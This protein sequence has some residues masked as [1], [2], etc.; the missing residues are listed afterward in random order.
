MKAK[1]DVDGA[2]DALEK[3]ARNDPKNADHSYWLARFLDERKRYREAIAAYQECIR[4][5]PDFT[6]ARHR[7]GV[8]LYLN[9]QLDQG[10]QTTRETV[11]LFPGDADSHYGLGTLLMVASRTDESIKWFRE[12]IRID[13]NHAQAQCNLG[14]ALQAQGRFADAFEHFRRGHEVGSK[15]GDWDYPSGQWVA[16]AQRLAALEQLLP[17]VL[18]GKRLAK[19]AVERALSWRGSRL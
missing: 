3:A 10:I 11:R 4:R 13:P 5:R 19:N 6:A 12:A 8:A 7:L 16:E 1:G 2:I 18:S 15:R 14:Q 17:E 9:G